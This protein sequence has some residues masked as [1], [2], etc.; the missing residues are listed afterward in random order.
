MAATE[1]A[2]ELVYFRELVKDLGFPPTGPSEL[3]GDNKAAIDLAYNPEHHNRTKHILRR[4]FFIR[5]LVE[6]MRI[7]VPYVSSAENDADFFTKALEPKLFFKFRAR[8]MNLPS[9]GADYR[10]G[11]EHGGVS[12]D[13]SVHTRAPPI[14]Q[15]LSTALQVQS[16][17]V[18][19][20]TNLRP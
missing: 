20:N 10:P 18:Q 1:A 2:K 8:I 19:S 13:M 5:E 16:N 7:A 6:D 14:P 11:L 4:H 17:T 12:N 15:T 3:S 9:A